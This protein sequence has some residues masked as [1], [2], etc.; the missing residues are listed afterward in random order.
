MSGK[1]RYIP[2]EYILP[3]S[4]SL[5]L[6]LSLSLS[7]SLVVPASTETITIS[8][9][10]PVTSTLAISQTTSN[11]FISFE[12]PRQGWETISEL[13]LRRELPKK[14]SKYR[15]NCYKTIP[16][17]DRLLVRPYSISSWL[18][19]KTGNERYRHE[20]LYIHFEDNCLKGYDSKNY[21]AL[22]EPFNYQQIKLDKETRNKL[23]DVEIVYLED[24]DMN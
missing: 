15:G 17:S 12:D 18:N 24:L 3:L 6:S 5:F 2:P 20:P 19:P 8:L 21:Y 14:I 23:S 9:S 22:N 13:H 10:S 4:L 7:V 16:Q 1:A 11:H